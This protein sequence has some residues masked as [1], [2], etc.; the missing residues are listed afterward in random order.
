MK[1]TKIPSIAN[2]KQALGVFSTDSAEVLCSHFKVNKWSRIKPVR[3]EKIGEMTEDDYKNVDFGFDLRL[4]ES[5]ASRVLSDLFGDKDWPYLQPRSGIDVCRLHDFSYYNHKAVSPFD[6][7]CS[8]SNGT[9][10]N[11]NAQVAYIIYQNEFDEN[12]E[13]KIHD[14]DLFDSNCSWGVMWRE[15]GSQYI[16]YV[17]RGPD[18]IEVIYPIEQ[19]GEFYIPIPVT[20]YVTK[21][22]ELCAVILKPG[23]KYY[24]VPNSLRTVQVKMLSNQE[25]L[26]FKVEGYG[27]YDTYMSTGLNSPN[28][29]VPVSFINQRDQVRRVRYT[30]E[31]IPRKTNGYLPLP[32]NYDNQE[33]RMSVIQSLGEFYIQPGETVDMNI[34]N[35]TDTV[36][37]VPVFRFE[38]SNNDMI[39][40]TYR[41]QVTI[42]D[43]ISAQIDLVGDCEVNLQP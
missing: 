2:V 30:V 27:S 14:F 4:N 43:A 17:G 31:I 7:N 16:N 32:G 41:I 25:L 18:D 28:I 19:M 23:D 9:E 22:I 1:L 8:P 36:D 34:G 26:S 33:S 6:I 24:L 39:G 5:L 12:V 42:D 40:A 10:N 11:P 38:D 35:G 21:T 37:G 3:H 13:I 20:P 29:Y 15:A